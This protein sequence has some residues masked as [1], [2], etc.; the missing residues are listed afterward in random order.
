MRWY[1]SRHPSRTWRLAPAHLPCN[2]KR[3]EEMGLGGGWRPK[4]RLD[5][6]DPPE[7]PVW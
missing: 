7:L 1:E 4:R 6:G 2:I 3:A 5:G